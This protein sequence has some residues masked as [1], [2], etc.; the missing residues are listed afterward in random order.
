MRRG[1]LPKTASVLVV[2]SDRVFLEKLLEASRRQDS[3][4]CVGLDPDLARLPAG[5]EPT[6][7]GAERFMRAIVEATADLVC[8]YKPNIAFWEAMGPPGLEAL[9]RLRQSIPAAIPVIVDAKRGDLDYS[10]ER[11][12]TALF[13]YYDFDALTVS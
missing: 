5:F 6:A 1:R 10:A 13:D 12:A 2:E 8:A 4:L 3:L 7:A 11:Y 9:A